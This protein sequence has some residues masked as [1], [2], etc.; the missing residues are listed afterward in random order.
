[1]QLVGA[2][3]RTALQTDVGALALGYC[4]VLRRRNDVAAALARRGRERH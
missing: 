1:M 4:G 2:G 3:A